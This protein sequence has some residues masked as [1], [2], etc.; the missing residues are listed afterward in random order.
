M[1]MVWLDGKQWCPFSK[2]D[3]YSSQGALIRQ[4]S[5]ARFSFTPKQQD[6]CQTPTTIV[7]NLI[8]V[9]FLYGKNSDRVT[10]RSQ[11][12]E[13]STLNRLEYL[14]GLKTLYKQKCR[15]LSTCR[16]HYTRRNRLQHS[17][18]FHFLIQAGPMDIQ[19]PRSL[20]PIVAASGE[21]VSDNLSFHI[22]HNPFQ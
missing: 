21:G 2:T 12:I 17:V 18:F 3:V 15:G 19:Q 20:G 4:T 5:T 9:V 6:A 7:T 14:K 11:C 22:V 16:E 10:D 1:W 13:S 8:Y